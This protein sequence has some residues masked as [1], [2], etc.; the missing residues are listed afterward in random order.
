[1]EHKTKWIASVLLG[2][3][4]STSAR[5]AEPAVPFPVALDSAAVTVK[6]LQHSGSESLFI[7]NG[8]LMGL[9]Y[10]DATG[11]VIRVC[12]TDVW[13]ARIDTSEDPE[14]PKI[15][16]A[17]HAFSGRGDP[18]SWSKRHYPTG[19]P[20][21]NI[22]IAEASSAGS[23]TGRL[24]LA[25][26]VAAVTTA[27]ATH[28]IRVLSQANVFQIVTPS[29][30]SIEAAPS[31]AGRPPVQFLPPAETGA[32]GGVQWLRQTL[33]GD[34]DYKGME[35][36]VAITGKGSNWV[37]AV[38]TSREDSNPLKAAIKLA[39]KSLDEDSAAQV[40]EHEQRW[41]KYWARS[42]VELAIP[43]FQNWW[44]R[45][46]YYLG[47]FSKPGSVAVGL[48]AGF[49]ALG[50]WHNSYKNNYNT[51]QTYCSPG[52]VNHP[53]LVEPLIEMF[54]AHLPRARWL[55]KTCFV[56]CE[57]AF[58][59]SDVWPYEPD[60][61]KCKSRNRRQCAYMPWGF[62]LGMNGMVATTLWEYYL[63]KP[64]PSYLKSRIYPILKDMAVFNCS[65]MEKSQRDANGKAV[66]APS[67]YP[68]QGSFGQTNTPWD[69][70]FITYGLEAAASA[71]EVLKCDSDLVSRIRKN[72][73]IMPPYPTEPDPEQENLPVVMQWLGGKLHEKPLDN[74]CSNTQ[75]VYPGAQVTWFSPE[76][77]KELFKRT[78]RYQ[79]PRSGKGNC[80]VM[81]QIA[82][83]RLGMSEDA[84]ESMLEL[85]RPCQRPNGLFYWPGHGHYISEQAGVAR[86]ITELLLQSVENVIRIFP[87]WPKD[88]DARFAGL[89]A[90]GGFLVTAE[91][92]LGK[93]DRVEITSTVGG[94][95]RLVSPWV[96]TLVN[97]N[98][99]KAD[100]RGVIECD[101]SRDEVIILTD[102][103]RDG[104]K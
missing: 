60:P 87:A 63:Y 9:V 3:L 27:G 83:A 26:A 1:M 46:V 71:A 79:Y 48:K 69:V 14:L 21:A 11:V 101:T 28:T 6:G 97:G 98:V 38:V 43:E 30:V 65:L 36:V 55:A 23:I 76:D 86:A 95:L 92:K 49:D 13:D 53:E 20:F 32:K 61:E 100:A 24:D 7:G 40:A 66:L 89:R 81:I 74:H 73:E 91:Q 4:F 64:D 50:G 56:G 16:P 96:E 29:A 17:T 102:A 31:F 77:Q 33:P 54:Y 62:S 67:L 72:L 93:V 22:R 70:A 51:Q 25:R 52:P 35:V 47:C 19:V 37:V 34:T 68:E 78:I 59:H 10:K 5:A 90:Q 15:D 84:V 8:D 44:Y 94:K 82:R 88:K 75:P 99:V 58:I 85:Y 104:V 45:Q 42:G 57:G 103:N 80:M 41:Q 18:A 2:L 12:K 39:K